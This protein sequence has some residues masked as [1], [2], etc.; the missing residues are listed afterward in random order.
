MKKI[1]D[2]LKKCLVTVII[3]VSGVSVSPAGA[4]E[5]SFT[6]NVLGKELVIPIVDRYNY[7]CDPE[8]KLPLHCYLYLPQME[9][10]PEYGRTLDDPYFIIRVGTRNSNETKEE[11]LKSL[12][13]SLKNSGEYLRF[14]NEAYPEY[15][16][17]DVYR[18]NDNS[19]CF[20][21]VFQNNSV[22]NLRKSPYLR[23][24]KLSHGSCF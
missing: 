4:M 9:M 22:D 6:K 21:A 23:G 17:G 18:N 11:F 14:L 20:D 19:V 3:F 15:K 7:K 13:Y 8:N 1:L 12:L 2:S 16:L 24:R 10:K 5:K